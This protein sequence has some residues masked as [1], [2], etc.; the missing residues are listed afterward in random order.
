MRVIKPKKLD[1]NAYKRIMRS[2]I[3]KAGEDIKRDFEKTTKTWN[4]Q[5]EFVIEAKLNVS[6][7]TLFV[8]TYDQIYI[9]VSAGTGLHGP[10]HA[11][12]PIFAGFFTG[13]SDKKFLAYQEEYERATE[14]GVIDSGP[15]GKFGNWVNV[16]AVMHPGIEPREFDVAMEELWAPELFSRMSAQLI[17]ANR[18]AG[19]SI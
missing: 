5:P 15:H 6:P 3:V 10:K 2:T 9:W 19:H 17:V 18:Q 7:M 12:Y 8:G 13:K 1:A 16:P 14:P 11:E 4:H